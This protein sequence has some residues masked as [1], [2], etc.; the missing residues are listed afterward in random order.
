MTFPVWK[1]TPWANFHV[2]FC[3]S[4]LCHTKLSYDAC[5]CDKINT[6]H[7]DHSHVFFLY[8][9]LRIRWNVFSYASRILF[10]HKVMSWFTI[11]FVIFTSLNN[12]LNTSN[13]FNPEYPHKILS[14]TCFI[15]F[16]DM[17]LKVFC[18]LW[19]FLFDN[20]C[21]WKYYLMQHSWQHVYS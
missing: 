2:I 7:M 1:S 14:C 16:I 13:S 20:H 15:I 18:S 12:S 5:V 11:D 17:L 3:L 9:V 10:A 4:Y 19:Y 8:D 6:A 21:Y